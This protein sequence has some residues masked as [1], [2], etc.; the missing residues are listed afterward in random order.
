ME[1]YSDIELAFMWGVAMATDG[2]VPV[3]LQMEV[4]ARGL[5]TALENA[6]G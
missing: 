5:D 6:D 2:V 1:Q 3:D 4:T